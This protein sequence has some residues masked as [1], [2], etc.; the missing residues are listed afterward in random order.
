MKTTTRFLLLIFGSGILTGCDPSRPK[1]AARQSACRIQ[2]IMA[3]AQSDVYSQQEETNFTYNADGNL[4]QK[5]F[6]RTLSYPNGI[7]NQLYTVMDTYTYDANGF[8]TTSASQTSEQTTRPNNTIHLQ[9]RSSTTTYSYTD[10]RLTGYEARDQNPYGVVTRSTVVL[11][12]D[13]KGE[14]LTKTDTRTPET[15]PADAPEKPSGPVQ[16]IWTYKSGQVID[17]VEKNETTESR[18]LTLQNG[19]VTKMALP[20]GYTQQNTYDNQQ[21]LIKTE[22]FVNNQLTG[23]YTQEWS[24]AKPAISTLPA[25]KGHPPMLPEFGVTG[26]LSKYSPYAINSQTNAIQHIS[27]KTSTPTV[28]AQGLVESTTGEIRLLHPNALPQRTAL[29]ETYTYSNCQ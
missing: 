24:N 5:A 26:V 6:K 16:R 15:V 9:Q 1:E 17:Y 4:T 3:T 20:G 2:K 12:Y 28:N 18:P 10:E 14:L 8:L 27:E 7:G 19:L 25:F 29:T 21:R 22:E 23:Y 13:V 11:N